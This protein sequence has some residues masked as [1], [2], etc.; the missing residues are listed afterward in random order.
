MKDLE[1]D[2]DYSMPIITEYACDLM[3]VD[4]AD[5][6]GVALD[7]VFPDLVKEGGKGLTKRKIDEKVEELQNVYMKQELKYFAEQE[8]NGWAESEEED[9]DEEKDDEEED[10]EEAKI[11]ERRR[12]IRV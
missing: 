6:M 7:T 4:N 2:V 8:A 11:Q 9:E 5:F 1:D 10:K 12:L 3:G